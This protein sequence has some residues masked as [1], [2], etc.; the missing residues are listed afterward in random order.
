[1][2]EKLTSLVLAFIDIVT[3]T[4]A[5]EISQARRPP[6]PDTN[7]R[8]FQLFIK[9]CERKLGARSASSSLLRAC[10]CA[11]DRGGLGE[12][13]DDDEI[14]FMTCQHT[15]ADSCEQAKFYSTSGSDYGRG[16]SDLKAG[17][18]VCILEGGKTPFIPR[19]DGDHYYP[20]WPDLHVWK[21]ERRSS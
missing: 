21:N 7:P 11:M 3:T 4:A 20:C 19:K 17:D 2:S 6:L 18:L 8:A 12:V 15:Y 16:P 14:D 13:Q 10:L 9:H 5:L 1:M